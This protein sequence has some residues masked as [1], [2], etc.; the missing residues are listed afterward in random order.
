MLDTPRPG[1]EGLHWRGGTD[2][3]AISRDREATLPAHSDQAV[4]LRRRRIRDPLVA[5][6]DPVELAGRRLR[7][8]GRLRR[9]AG[10]R[11]GRRHRHRGDRR[12]QHAHRRAGASRPLP[13]PRQFRPGRAGRRPVEPVSARPRYRATVPRG[14]DPGRHGR[15][16]RIGLPVDAGR[17]RGRSRCLPRHGHLH[18]RRRSRGPA[19]H[20]VARRRRRP[21][22]AALQFHEGP[23]EHRGHA[24]AVPAEAVCRSARSA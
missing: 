22:C 20:G 24:R 1:N 8:R 10:A 14:R 19:R 18:V 17:P 16:P 4:A 23:A 9:A 7:H 5:G 12:D 11:T 6:D 13:T 3:A 21:A 15:L 2:P